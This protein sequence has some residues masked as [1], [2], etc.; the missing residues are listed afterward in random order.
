MTAH[1]LSTAEK[2]RPPIQM[3]CYTDSHGN[4]FEFNVGRQGVTEIREVGEYG[5]YAMIP[6][7]EVWRGDQLVARF[8]QHKLEHIFY[9]QGD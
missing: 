2:S 8:S 4:P 5:E 7:V 1:E 6:W 3:I 9:V